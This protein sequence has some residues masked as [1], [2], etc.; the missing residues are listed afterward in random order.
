M[1]LAEHADLPRLELFSLRSHKSKVQLAVT[2]RVSALV[3]VTSSQSPGSDLVV[4]RSL[5]SFL[6]P[7]LV[8]CWSDKKKVTPVRTPISDQNVPPFPREVPSEVDVKLVAHR[9]YLLGLRR[10]RPVW[11]ATHHP[12][13][14][15]SEQI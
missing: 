14:S 5:V 7:I 13:S 4:R 1:R 15:S 9:F 8:S 12:P 10:R 3:C 6:V 2:T 11:A